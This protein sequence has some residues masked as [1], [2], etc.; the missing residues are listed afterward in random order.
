[1]ICKICGT[2]ALHSGKG[3]CEDCLFYRS[4]YLKTY[5]EMDE[6]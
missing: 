2:D 1:M 4:G 6:E 5:W 3:C